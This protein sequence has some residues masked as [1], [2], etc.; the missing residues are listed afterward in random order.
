MSENQA[1]KASE[2][3]PHT[4]SYA[5]EHK[6]W[7]RCLASMKQNIACKDMIQAVIREHFDGAH[8]AH[9]AAKTVIDSFGID[10]VEYVLANT[11]QLQDWDGRFSRRNRAWANTIPVVSDPDPWGGDKRYQFMVNSHPAILDGFLDLVRQERKL[12]SAQQTSAL[13]QLSALKNRQPEH[14]APAKKHPEASR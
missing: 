4:F 12:L 1:P 13:D 5:A 10:R 6:E 7:D 3:Y 9:D 14:K 8:L 2:L 11:V